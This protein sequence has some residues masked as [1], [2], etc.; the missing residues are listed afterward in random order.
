M[1]AIFN[2]GEAL[3]HSVTGM[4]SR[5]VLVVNQ[6]DWHNQH[7]MFKRLLSRAGGLDRDHFYYASLATTNLIDFVRENGIKAIVA[8]GEPVLRSLTGEKDILRWRGRVVDWFGTPLI[9]IIAPHKLLPENIS[10]AQLAINKA[11][12][13]TSLVNPPRF[14]G[15]TML[16]LEF[17][18]QVAAEGFTRKRAN[19]LL[20]PSPAEFERWADDYEAALDDSTHPAWVDGEPPLLSWD[21]ETVYKQKTKDEGELE[22]SKLDIEHLEN[23]TLLRISFAYQE[24]TGVSV[25]WDPAYL[26]IIRRLLRSTGPKV[27]WNGKTFDV[28]VVEKVGIEVRGEV[29]DYMDGWHVYQSDLPKGLE[30]VTSFTSDLLPW[31]HLNNADPVL[32]SAIDADA[33]LR[34]AI[35]IRR[36]LKSTGQWNLY[37]WLFHKVMEPLYAANRRGNYIDIAKRDSLREEMGAIIDRLDA[38]MQPLVP[39]ELFPRKRYKRWP[40]PGDE[41]TEP[42]ESI[43]FDWP[44]EAEDGTFTMRSV[45]PVRT[46][47]EVKFCSICGARDVT[48][49]EHFASVQGPP[50]LDKEGNQRIGKRGPMFESIQS[51]CK[52]AEGKIEE[53]EADV[54]EWDEILPFN[55]ASPDQVKAYAKHFGHPVGQDARD[56]T[57]ETMDKTHM[58]LLIGRYGAKFPIYEKLAERSKLAKTFGTYIYDPDADGLIHQTYKNAP[59]TPRLSGANYNLMNVGKREDNPWAVKAREQIIARPGFRFVQADS[60]SIEAVI[61]GY[62]MG[63]R[64]YAELATQSI[65]AWVVA[66]KNGIVWD[67]SPE[68]VDYLKANFKDD[69][70]KMKTVNYLTNFGGGPYLMWKT[71]PKSFPTK[72]S[73]EEAQQALFDLLPKLPEYHHRMR[74]RAQKEG[75]LEIPGW[76]FRH[77]YYDVFTRTDNGKVKY[78][79]DSKKVVA[80]YP[81]GSAALFLRENTLLLAYGD[82]AAEWLG[83]EPLGLTRGW[84]EYMPAN[85]AV[86]DGYTL[87]VPDG[88]EWEAAADLE[89]VLTRPIK[90]LQNLQ[91]GCEVDISPVNGNWGSYHEKKNPMGL[92][93]VKAVRVPL[94]Q[95]G[96]MEEAA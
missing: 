80:L 92:K 39:R 6:Y 63:D 12:G 56:S 33:A 88:M 22:E 8:V 54:I 75:F 34:N 24:F 95:F 61:Q 44:E 3:N 81:Q 31:K 64:Q 42:F 78:G 17:A 11:Q 57:K 53:R 30:F 55:P 93:M 16:D 1:G 96:E 50:K 43:T 76:K 21:V 23:G 9:P 19:Y 52:L 38:E 67:G 51:A 37:Y 83:I 68:Q 84:M 86:H 79:K 7:F 18:L 13:I 74:V 14:Q 25:P 72:A 49:G 28:P 27:V 90:Q 58:K 41:P 73:A 77:Y 5:K 94:I 60:S 47:G 32:Y 46:K 82:E 29:F 20:D 85:Y 66:R 4:G 45:E 40:G 70:N 62:W 10:D 89:R 26:P 15:V 48:K 59:S 65:H 69:Y 71:D 2:K 36:K 87:E 35:W 91:I